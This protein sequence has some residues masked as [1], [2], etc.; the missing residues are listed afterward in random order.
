[1]M[2]NQ[3]LTHEL[4]TEIKRDIKIVSET[5]EKHMT[6]PNL[7]AAYEYTSLCMAREARKERLYQAIVEKS[8]AGLVYATIIGIGAAIVAYVKAH[9]VP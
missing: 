9:W 5:L 4:L 6:D 3:D 2:D 1:M 7:R 8:L